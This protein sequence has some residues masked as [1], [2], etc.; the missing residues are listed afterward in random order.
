MSTSE[1][2]RK[3]SGVIYGYNSRTVRIWAPNNGKQETYTKLLCKNIQY[4][5]FHTLINDFPYIFKSAYK[6][7][8]N[9]YV[10]YNF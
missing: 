10:I 3:K 4:C 6:C 7:K 9:E 1:T 5:D 8:L 2:G